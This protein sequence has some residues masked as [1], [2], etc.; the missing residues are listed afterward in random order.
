MHPLFCIEQE[1]SLWTRDIEAEIVPTCRELGIKILA[2]APLGRGFLTGGIR[3]TDVLDAY[4]TRRGN[5][6]PRANAENITKNLA[7]VDNLKSIADS[8]GV[9]VG[10]LALAWVHHQGEDVIPI[11]GT[12]SLK[13][14]QENVEAAKVVLSPA[15]LKAIDELFPA[16]AVVGTRYADM[17]RTFHGNVNSHP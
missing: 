4:D 12:T 16:E 11:P 14:L 7:L 17:S 1:W 3:S 15:D 8:K 6:F 13:H 9:T 2:Y 10:Q 5:L